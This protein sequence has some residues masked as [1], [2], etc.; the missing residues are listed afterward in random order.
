MK[1]KAT[2]VIAPATFGYG[3]AS[4]AISIA[5]ALRGRSRAEIM[6]VGD[7]ICLNYLERSGAFDAVIP[8]EPDDLPDEDVLRPDHPTVFVAVTDFARAMAAKRRGFPLLVVDALYWMWNSDPMDVRAADGYLCLAFPGVAE[9]MARIDPPCS[10]LREIPQ[11]A[12]PESDDIRAPRDGLIL[13]FGGGVTPFGFS[14]NYCAT[15]VRAVQAA[16]SPM[17]NKDLLVA[18]SDAARAELV[19]RGI[20]ADIRSLS[21]QEMTSELASRRSL[22]TLPGLSIMWDA[23]RTRIPTYVLPGISY[24]Q[25][26]LA[27]AYRQYFQN[28][29][30]LTW[31]DLD[32]YESL[33]AG[34]VEGEGVRAATETADQLAQDSRGIFNLTNWL[35]TELQRSHSSLSL[36][37][38]HPWGDFSGAESVADEALSI[39]SKKG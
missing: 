27:L 20:H 28:L 11:I 38:E 21:L 1:S 29:P 25:H 22:V 35:K 5:G 15:L 31:D 34:M 16:R 24:S 6:A 14:Y 32:G 13:N 8:A 17:D 39:L 23:K 4:H 19:A 12:E 2:I 26:R 30:I 18:C 33:P 3:P 9:R 36:I 7:G 10:T 37:P